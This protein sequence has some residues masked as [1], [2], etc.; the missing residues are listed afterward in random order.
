MATRVV[1]SYQDKTD[2]LRLAV[3]Q[4]GVSVQIELSPVLRG[5][6]FVVQP[7]SVRESVENEFGFAEIQVVSLADLYA[8]KLCAAFDRQHPCDFFDVL[9]LLENEGI[10]EQIRQAFIAYLFSHPRPSE[11]LLAPRWKDID[12]QYQGEFSGMARRSITVSELKMAAFSAFK[13]LLSNFTEQEKNLIVSVYDSEPLW[14]NS[15]IEHAQY[16]PAVIWKLQNIAK[17]PEA[18]R[19]SSQQALKKVLGV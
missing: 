10:T 5:T 19:E 4:S 16:L 7:L 15:P 9:L 18:K 14:K 12:G 2:A 11:E 8:G 6:V 3:Q 1:K 13:I 17:M